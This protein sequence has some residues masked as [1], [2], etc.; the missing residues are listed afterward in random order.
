[1][2]PC[3]STVRS[4]HRVSLVVPDSIDTDRVL[5]RAG[6]FAAVILLVGVVQY[7][8]FR[9]RF[10]IG[11]QLLATVFWV[12]VLL[13]IPRLLTSRWHGRIATALFLA[14]FFLVL[15]G[16]KAGCY[17]APHPDGPLLLAY[18]WDADGLRYGGRTPTGYLCRGRPHLLQLAVGYLSIGVGGALT[19]GEPFDSSR[20]TPDG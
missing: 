18:E 10:G 9:T 19:A 8:S 17:G 12:T 13:S 2:R 6:V 3:R 11:S 20:S 7:A 1:M 15:T 5:L 4:L 16:L 14:G